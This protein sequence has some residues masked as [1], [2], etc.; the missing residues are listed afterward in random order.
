MSLPTR[1]GVAG[2]PI[3]HSLSP[4][5]H[6]TAYAALG[7]GWVYDAHEVDEGGLAAFLAGMGDEWRG[8][9]LTMP[10]KQAALAHCTTVSEQAR[11]VS[12]VN[13]VVLDA[14]RGLAGHNTDV[15]G[16]VAAWR[17]AGIDAVRSA[18]VLGGGATARSAVAALDSIGVARVTVLVR[19]PGR[20]GLLEPLLSSL[21]MQS[22]VGPLP[23]RGQPAGTRRRDVDLLVCTIPAAGQDG[24]AADG[25]LADLVGH[26]A[27]V[28][29]V[30][31]GPRD[32]PVVAV[33]R[34]A[35]L[36]C[37]DG[38]GLLLHQAVLQVELMTGRGPAPLE[39]MREAGRAE[40]SR[41]ARA[42]AEPG[43]ASL[44]A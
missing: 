29:D 31:Y 6:R 9:S 5:L 10:L 35:G 3:S 17:D 14:E 8:L 40:L 36:G 26:A 15:P 39:R 1:C 30:A 27:A 44:E 20:A 11:H 23:N 18:V 13:T 42:T 34:R 28:S 25:T 4:V 7:L 24:L 32:S 38:F 2:S 22:D 41:Q 37:A 19:S 16:F 33:A 43:E 21:A 12:A